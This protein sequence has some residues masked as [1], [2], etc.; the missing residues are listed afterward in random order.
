M[1]FGSGN[2]R[3]TKEKARKLFFLPRS[4][5]LVY[6]NILLH[7]IKQQKRKNFVWLVWSL[8]PSRT[9]RKGFNPFGSS[10][11]KERK[12][13]T[14]NRHWIPFFCAISKNNKRNIFGVVLWFLARP[15]PAE[16]HVE[17]K[18]FVLLEVKAW[19]ISARA[20]KRGRRRRRRVLRHSKRR[21]LRVQLI[22]K[23]PE[24]WSLP[25]SEQ[26]RIWD[27]RAWVG[28]DGGEGFEMLFY[29]V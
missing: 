8:S 10:P 6:F 20:F 12:Q 26:R 9:T 27:G 1:C 21:H 13:K 14:P 19:N 4:S 17:S 15:H 5:V 3:D 18:Y 16:I 22:Y 28:E 2:M 7:F 25:S 29:Q 24:I 11:L 23:I